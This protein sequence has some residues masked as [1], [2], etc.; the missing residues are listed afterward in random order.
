M[1]KS[2]LSDSKKNSVVARIKSHGKHFEIMVYADKAESLRKTGQGNIAAIL[3]Y[4]GIFSDLRK[5]LKIKESELE[6][7]FGTTD[8]YKI[9]EKIIKDGEVQFPLSH[10]EEARDLKYRQIID[11]LASSCTNPAGIPYP[12]ERIK[13]AMEQVGARIDD[14]KP[15]EMQALSILKLIQKIIPIKLAMKRIALKIPAQFTGKIYGYVKDFEIHEEWL[16]DGSLSCVIE[17]PIKLQS[18]FFDRLN[19]VTHGEAITEEM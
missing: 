18:E 5:G 11:F 1:E 3:E 17:I 4:P 14:S 12:A 19:A 6:E 9:A 7:V 8:I 10:R 15:A 13:N 2:F 16:S